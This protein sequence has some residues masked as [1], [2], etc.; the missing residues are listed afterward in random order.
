MTLLTIV[1]LIGLLAVGAWLLQQR[2]REQRPADD[3]V[4]PSGEPVDPAW[5][6]A[7][8]RERDEGEKLGTALL[9]AGQRASGL[10]T[11][12]ELSRKPYFEGVQKKLAAS[13][14]LYGD[15]LQVFLSVQFAAG[16][17]GAGVAILG[18]V[19][20][21]QP[22]I[23][24]LVAVLVAAY[25]YNRLRTTY[26][27]RIEK[28]NDELPQFV[29]TLL[30]PLAAGNTIAR[31]LDFTLQRSDGVIPEEVASMRAAIRAKALT[32]EEAYALAGQRLGT[33]DA[34]Q[35]MT[36][37]YQGDT[38]GA[39]VD[40]QLVQ[41]SAEMRKTQFQ[42]RRERLNKLP[43]KVMMIFF[44]HFVPLILLSLMLPALLRVADLV[45]S[46]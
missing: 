4:K 45:S 12:T 39:D 40:N 46:L 13:G 19:G 29:E 42:Q 17:I 16:V 2:R 37:L 24:A 33:P 20:I 28:V 6:R 27:K 5:Q 26:T 30:M 38:K 35:L 10:P 23:A 36:T 21:L 9:A 43:T 44:F 14:G 31:S 15:S 18:V 41:L 22:L 34:Q 1:S 32:D 3:V 25:P 8:A 7:I 11:I